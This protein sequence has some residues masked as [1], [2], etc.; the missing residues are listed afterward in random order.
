MESVYETRN[1]DTPDPSAAHIVAHLD[2]LYPSR[3]LR[4]AKVNT[5][6]ELQS[7]GG[8]NCARSLGGR[9]CRPCWMGLSRESCD[10]LCP[11]DISPK[12]DDG[13]VGFGGEHGIES[14][15]ETREYQHESPSAAG[16]GAGGTVRYGGGIAPKADV[17]TVRAG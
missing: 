6:W 5:L 2:G 11:L 12:Y 16:G 17:V 8:R 10:P 4:Q 1:K 7:A 13:A 14:I 9:C 3:Y 15:Y